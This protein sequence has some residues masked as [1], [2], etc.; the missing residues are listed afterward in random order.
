V[1]A[2]TIPGFTHPVRELW[3][4]DILAATGFRVGPGS[5]WA[6]RKLPRAESGPCGGGGGGGGAAAAAAA[7][8]GAVA[9]GGEGEEEALGWDEPAS[10]ELEGGDDAGAATSSSSAAG[11]GPQ[12]QQ[13]QQ[14]EYSPD[15][16]RSLEFIDPSLVNYDLLEALV[17]HVVGRTQRDGPTAL[18]QVRR[19]GW[20]REG[21]WGAGHA[22]LVKGCVCRESGREPRHPDRPPQSPPPT[23]PQGWRDAPPGALAPPRG[24]DA[25]AGAI[26]IFMPGAPEID[27]LVRLLS[28]SPRVAAAAGGASLRVL[29][30]HGSLPAGHQARVF[31]RAGRGVVKIV[32]ATNVAETSITIDDVVAVIDTGR[33]KETGC[34]AVGWR[35][36]R[37]G[38]PGGRGGR[39]EA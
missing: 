39:S 22:A 38:R 1:S 34:G 29:P 36:W 14:Q 33:V 8:A 2:L 20:P 23:P 3:L 17:A 26:L 12:Q 30:L 5:R 9:G 21:P 18:L 28:S 37:G 19:R 13:Q 4:E 25:E 32:V 24:R 15:V 7:A 16:L 27:R 11:P 6:K 31:E 35:E 10:D